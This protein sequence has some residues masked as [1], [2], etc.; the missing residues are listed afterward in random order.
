TAVDLQLVNGRA[1]AALSPPATDTGTA[2]V[3][4][5]F[6]PAGATISYTGA[7]NVRIS[8][9]ATFFVSSVSPGVGNPNG[10]DTVQILGGG[11]VAPVRVTFNGATATVKSTTGSAITVVT[12]SAAAARAPVGVGQPAPVPVAVTI[13]VNKPNQAVDSI[14]QGF[15]YALGGGTQ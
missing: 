13:N 7:A 5:T 6:T 14:P 2:A 8:Q 4:A 10:G 12:P 15:T 1:S 9:A 3:T 11:F